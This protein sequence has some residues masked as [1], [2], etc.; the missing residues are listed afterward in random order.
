MNEFLTILNQELLFDYAN[1]TSISMTQLEEIT[2]KYDE[3]I[4]SIGKTKAEKIQE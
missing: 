4:G 2:E 1:E 3:M